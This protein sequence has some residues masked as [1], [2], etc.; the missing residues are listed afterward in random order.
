MSATL[1]PLG[2]G[3]LL[4]LCHQEIRTIQRTRIYFPRPTS[5]CRYLMA[6]RDADGVFFRFAV[7]WSR[8]VQMAWA[9]VWTWRRVGCS[10]AAV[11]LRIE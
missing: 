4:Y 10:I 11:V 2:M 9:K 3:H 6:F 5:K 7:S 8:W 1:P